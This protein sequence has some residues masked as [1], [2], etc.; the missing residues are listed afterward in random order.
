MDQGRYRTPQTLVMG[1]NH[2][3]T[4]SPTPNG[5]TRSFIYP[6]PPPQI[7][8]WLIQS[9]DRA[10]GPSS[11][12]VT[13][14]QVGISWGFS[15]LGA[16]LA[17]WEHTCRTKLSSSSPSHSC[18][19]PNC[20]KTTSR[21]RACPRASSTSPSHCIIADK[22]PQCLQSH[23]PFWLLLDSPPH[24][25]PHHVTQTSH[26]N[27]VTNVNTRLQPLHNHLTEYDKML[28][29]GNPTPQA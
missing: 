11:N 23:H 13:K 20:N 16:H 4:F 25:Q 17:M 27:V 9:R 2:I 5:S 12:T 24:S 15:R 19:K 28:F 21:D 18:C 6:P 26:K 14:L 22:V 1:I 7:N 3:T 29:I 10:E 8:H